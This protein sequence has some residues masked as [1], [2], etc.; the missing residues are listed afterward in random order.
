MQIFLTAATGFIGR[1][2]TRMFL[3]RSWEATALVRRPEWRMQS[4][5]GWSVKRTGLRSRANRCG[6]F[7]QGNKLFHGGHRGSNPR[8]GAMNSPVSVR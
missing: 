7:K 3:A 8:G 6:S 2:R 1:E 5:T 4:L